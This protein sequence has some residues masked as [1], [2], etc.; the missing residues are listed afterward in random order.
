MQIAFAHF[1]VYKKYRL[2]DFKRL[3]FKFIQIDG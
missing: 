3:G 1:E 2:I